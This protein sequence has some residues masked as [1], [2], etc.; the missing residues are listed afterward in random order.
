MKNIDDIYENVKALQAKITW[1]KGQITTYKA[2]MRQLEYRKDQAKSYDKDG[3][4]EKITTCFWRL[5]EAKKELVKS[6]TILKNY[7]NEN[8]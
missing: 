7:L 4:Q 1:R 3:W 5:D 6:L 8:L 2:Q